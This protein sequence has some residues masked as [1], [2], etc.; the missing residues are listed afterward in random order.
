MMKRVRARGARTWRSVIAHRL[1]YLFMLLAHCVYVLDLLYC[2]MPC[3]QCCTMPCP[4]PKYSKLTCRT[5]RHAHLTVR[6]KAE[7]LR[8]SSYTLSYII[9]YHIRLYYIIVQYIQC[10][11]IYIY[12]EREREMYTYIC[13]YIYIERE[14]EIHIY[15]Y[16]YI[17]IHIQID[18]YVYIL[19]FMYCPIYYVCCLILL[20]TAQYVSSYILH[21]VR[22]LRVSISEGLTQANS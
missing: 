3:H 2:L 9:L 19:L 10:V 6:R 1:G 18:R 21:P 13:I 16:I 15:I 8:G 22:L 17:Y 7:R 11:Y 12:I 4:A 14:R 20:Y 5:P